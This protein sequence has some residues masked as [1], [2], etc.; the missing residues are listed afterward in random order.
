[1]LSCVILCQLQKVVAL[2]EFFGDGF[3][4]HGV[5]LIT[6]MTHH[7]IAADQPHISETLSLPSLT[8]LSMAIRIF[9][10]AIRINANVRL[11]IV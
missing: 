5:L 2:V 4:C 1:M 9:V 10:D 6:L 7:K 11:S 3:E 8:H